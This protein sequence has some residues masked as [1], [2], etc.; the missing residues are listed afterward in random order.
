MV[1]ENDEYFTYGIY[2]YLDDAEENAE[3]FRPLTGK[4]GQTLSK[5]KSSSSLHPES[6]EREEKLR[7]SSARYYSDGRKLSF[8]DLLGV[9]STRGVTFTYKDVKESLQVAQRETENTNVYDKTK[10]NDK[11]ILEEKILKKIS[12]KLLAAAELTPEAST[13]VFV[14]PFH[15]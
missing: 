12:E 7:E 8:L 2:S 11:T 14:L 5:S 6:P 13:A 10:W 15:P 1:A 9:S 4:T 3:N